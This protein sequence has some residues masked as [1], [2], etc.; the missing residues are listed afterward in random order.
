M[1]RLA[2][3]SAKWT[4][5]SKTN[6]TKLTLLKRKMQAGASK[7]AHVAAD[8]MVHEMK[9][10]I[11]NQ[12]YE[13]KPLSEVWTAK[14]DFHKLDPRI[15]IAS[16]DYLNSIQSEKKPLRGSVV[17]NWLL[18]RWLEY[19]TDGV[20]NLGAPTQKGEGRMPA[21]PHRGPA[22]SRAKMYIPGNTK[23][24]IRNAFAKR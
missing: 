16:G 4:A 7:A 22:L 6:I 13:W 23:E 3:F 18:G 2:T 1:A 20:P 15:L 19:G 21:R 5:E 14:K 17:G 10:M 8:V 24:L 9:D 11:E 12:T